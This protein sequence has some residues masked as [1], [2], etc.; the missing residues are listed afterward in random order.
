[1]TGGQHNYLEEITPRGPRAWGCFLG[2]GGG[3]DVT[4]SPFPYV[5]DNLS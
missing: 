4:W 2:G 1:M 5:N 3:G